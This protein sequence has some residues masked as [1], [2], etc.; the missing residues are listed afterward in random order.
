MEALDAS[1]LAVGD[2]LSWLTVYYRYTK[3]SSID[4]LGIC[5]CC[6]AAVVVIIITFLHGG[7]GPIRRMHYDQ[8]TGTITP[9]K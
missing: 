4:Q 2:R 1:E 7:S 9:R 8:L 3:I 6:C 5:P